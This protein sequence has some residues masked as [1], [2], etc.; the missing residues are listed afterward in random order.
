MSI[1][2]CSNANFFVHFSQASAMRAPVEMC[3]KCGRQIPIP[4]LSDHLQH[5]VDEELFGDGEEGG[6][7]SRSAIGEEGGHTSRSAIGE[8]GGHT[9]R[10]AIG[11]EGGHTSRSA[12]G[13]GGGHTSRSAI[14]EEG[15]HTSRSAIGEEGGHTSH[16]AFGEEG[17][18]IVIADSPKVSVRVCTFV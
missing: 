6:H 2:T 10:S 15:G 16:S 1:Y 12:F 5:C 14:G 11:E 4:L 3:L 9:S 13:E 18:T 7:T 8:E 17:E